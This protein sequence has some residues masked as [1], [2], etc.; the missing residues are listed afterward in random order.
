MINMNSKPIQVNSSG[1]FVRLV[2]YMGDDSS[3]A[4][5]A[6]VSYGAGTK[7]VTEDKDLTRFLM[8]HEH[9][10]PFAMA[11]V[12][13]HMKFPIFIHNQMVRHDRFHWNLMSGRYSVMPEEKWSPEQEEL[14]AQGKGNKQ[15]GS[16]ELSF[17]HAKRAREILI[18]ANDDAQNSYEILLE[19]GVCREQARTI[20]PLGQY[21]EGYATANLG[22]WLLFLKQ[23]LAPGAQKEIQEYAIA[24]SQ[25]LQRLFPTVMQAWEDYQLNAV[26]FSA[27]EMIWLRETLASNVKLLDANPDMRKESIRSVGITNIREAQEFWKKLKG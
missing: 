6:R 13:I 21:S 12:K 15:V 2:D 27:Q 10:S 24:I 4:Q 7:T 3:P 5:A 22:D 25:I 1:G 19:H 16:G 17:D 11:Q 20:L 18:T 14:R 8:R 9:F 26:T 23:R